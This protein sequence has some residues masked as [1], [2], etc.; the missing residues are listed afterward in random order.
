MH[1]TYSS[2]NSKGEILNGTLEAQNETVAAKM[3]QNQGLFVL[4][5][6]KAGENKIIHKGGIKIPFLS[7]RVALK[8]KII[9]TQQLAMMIKSGLPLIDALNALQEQTENHYFAQVIGEIT[10][11]VRGGK[12]LSICLE[13]YPNIFSRLYVSIVSSGE[14]SGKLDEVLG[15]LAEELE[16]DYDLITKI[17]GAVT[18]PI[19]IIGALIGI[20]ILML[21]FVIPQ[22]KKIFVD[23]NVQLPLVTKIILGVS[24][25]LINYWYI[26]LIVVLGIIFGLRAYAKTARGKLF[27]DNSKIKIPLVGKVVRKVYMARFCRTTGTLVASGLPILDI[28]KT[29]GEIINNQVYKNALMRIGDQVKSGKTFSEA[30]KKE[31]VF[32]AMIYHLIFVGEKSGKLDEVLLSMADFFDKEVEASTSNMANLVEPILIIIVGAGVGL[33]VAAVILP[34]YSLVNVI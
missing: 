7:D 18:Y 9:F 32:P 34:I 28:I 24:D 5:L 26:V 11:E 1:F 15:R 14:K 27:W 29:V 21:I 6:T 10:E 2:K 25:A 23:M 3:L 8:D 31:P 33:V 13:K 17:K 20:V 16:K 4:S 22:I 30:L 19:L 12:A